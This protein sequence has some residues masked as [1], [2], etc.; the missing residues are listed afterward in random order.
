M[1]LKQLKSIL[2]KLTKE[3]LDQEVKYLSAEFSISGCV[4]AVKKCPA[5]LYCDGDDD[6]SSLKTAKELKEE[7]EYS[8][9]DIKSG[10]AGT[11]EFKKGELLIYLD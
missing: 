1:K 7:Y 4:K 8:N 6:P 5:T 3:E 2:D 10:Q 11:I 9:D